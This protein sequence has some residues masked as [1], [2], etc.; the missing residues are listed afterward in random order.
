[1]FA[2]TPRLLLRPGWKEDAPA[3]TQAIG[4]FA[5]AGKLARVPWP[6]R[7]ENAESFL[8]A[9]HGPLP[10]FL[11]FA[12]T[13]GAPR[14]VGGIGLTSSE[15]GVELGYWIARAYWGLGFATEA[16]RAVVELADKG[17]RL[18]RLVAGHFAENPASARVLRKLG[19]VATGTSSLRPCLARNSVETCIDHVRHAGAVGDSGSSV[20]AGY[21]REDAMAA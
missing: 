14:L 5:V 9:D 20:G 10:N 19:F 3:L 1:M 21:D 18:P 8:S 13:H 15:K 2:R 12:R 7:I 6:Y 16:G 4:D 11:I 17:L